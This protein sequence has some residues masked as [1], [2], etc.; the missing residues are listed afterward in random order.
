M[1]TLTLQERR[2]A[3]TDALRSGEYNQCK[4]QLQDSKGYCCLGVACVVY[5]KLTGEELNKDTAGQLVGGTL[6]QNVQTFYGIEDDL[7]VYW[8]VR[9]GRTALSALNDVRNY[10]FNQIADVVDSN[11]RGLWSPESTN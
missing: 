1:S 7:G 11:P 8:C 10:T 2:K 6:P 4:G 3:F 9:G 5:E